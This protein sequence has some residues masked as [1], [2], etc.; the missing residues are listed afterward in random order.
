ML[1]IPQRTRGQSVSMITAIM[2]RRNGTLWNTYPS[3]VYPIIQKL[4]QVIMS[5]LPRIANHLER[6]R[7]SRPFDDFR[8][9]TLTSTVVVKNM[10]FGIGGPGQ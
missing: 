4:A 2:L 3:E 8:G 1:R 10:M 6:G 5:I 9:L 7:M